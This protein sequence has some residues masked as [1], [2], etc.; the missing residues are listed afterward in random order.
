MQTQ[1]KNTILQNQCN[2]CCD[3]H[4]TKTHA[5]HRPY[6]HRAR[7]QQQRKLYIERPL[8]FDPI[9]PTG[10]CVAL[11]CEMVGVGANNTSVLARVTMIS[12]DGKTIFDRFVQVE[13]KVT[14]YRTSVSG[15]RPEDLR[16]PDALPYG[17]CRNQVL[18]MLHGKV[19]VGH[20]LQNDLRVLCIHS[21][22]VQLIRDTSTYWRFMRRRA[23]GSLA[24]R[25]LKVLSLQFLGQSIQEGEHDSLEDARAA[26]KLYLLHKNEWDTTVLVQSSI[27]TPFPIVDHHRK[28]DWRNPHHCIDNL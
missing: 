23:D 5:L 22:P 6:S 7:R 26:M 28:K 9:A 15:I 17:E 10:N 3:M 18:H 24:A 13:E 25:S 21:H 11:D 1:E 16:S 27:P 19:L 2:S 12:T 14:N 8:S 20:G 4:P